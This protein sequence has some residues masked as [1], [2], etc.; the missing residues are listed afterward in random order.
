MGL[1][2][3]IEP[4]DI[5]EAINEIVGV[6]LKVSP[7]APTLKD[8]LAQRKAA[9]QAPGEA[10]LTIN[11]AGQ[12]KPIN[13]EPMSPAKSIPAAPASPGRND[14]AAGKLKVKQLPTIQGGTQSQLIAPP[15][16]ATK[17]DGLNGHH[18]AMRLLTAFRKRDFVGLGEDLEIIASLDY[19]GRQ[20]FNEIMLGLG[21]VD[22]SLDPEGLAELSA[23]TMDVFRGQ[24]MQ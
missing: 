18:L 13:P 9:Q 5:I 1:G 14:K 11:Q 17:A 23:S 2:D 24:H 22:P 21:Y 6:H 4:S 10:S 20:A 8:K 15:T 16:P 19:D 3:Q 7:S 12:I